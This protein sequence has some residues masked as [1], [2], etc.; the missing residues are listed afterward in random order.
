MPP[1]LYRAAGNLS[2]PG[3]G[4]AGLDPASILSV[5]NLLIRIPART[6]MTGLAGGRE[7]TCLNAINQSLQRTGARIHQEGKG[8]AMVKLAVDFDHAV[9]QFQDTF[10][11][12]QTEPG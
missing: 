5:A 4:H 12:R 6:G 2:K 3:R 7:D 9:V 1:F 8:G 11:Y 10:D